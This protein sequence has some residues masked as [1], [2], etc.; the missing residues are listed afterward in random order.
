[1]VGDGKEAESL[2]ESFEEGIVD[3]GLACIDVPNST[4]RVDSVNAEC[5]DQ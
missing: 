1:M 5:S 4:L 2:T 3:L